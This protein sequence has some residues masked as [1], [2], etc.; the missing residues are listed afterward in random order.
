[1]TE[2]EIMSVRELALFLDITEGTV[3]N[4]VCRNEIPYYKPHGKVYFLKEEIMKIILDAR[5][6]SIDE[7]VKART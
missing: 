6:A 4:M 5:V 2:K 1:M 3:R 7:Q